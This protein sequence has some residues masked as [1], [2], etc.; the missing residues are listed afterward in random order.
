MKAATS[1]RPSRRQEKELNRLIET[2]RTLDLTDADDESELFCDY[3]RAVEVFASRY[4]QSIAEV[5]QTVINA[6]V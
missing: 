5:E 4:H 2:C 3:Q 1:V 6:V